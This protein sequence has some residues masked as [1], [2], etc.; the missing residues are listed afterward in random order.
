MDVEPTRNKWSSVLC[1]RLINFQLSPFTS[2]S[3]APHST[4]PHSTAPHSTAPL[5]H[6]QQPLAAETPSNRRPRDR[7]GA[8]ALRQPA[9]KARGERV[10][11]CKTKRRKS[12]QGTDFFSRGVSTAVWVATDPCRKI[13]DNLGLTPQKIKKKAKAEPS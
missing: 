13:R 2:Y 7:R 6:I 4:A 12:R 9:Q 8:R 1:R 5:T 11:G 10:A 3:T